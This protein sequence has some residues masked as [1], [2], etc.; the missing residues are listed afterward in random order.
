MV[1][2]VMMK[3]MM[4]GVVCKR[5]GK[6]KRETE[7]RNIKTLFTTVMTDREKKIP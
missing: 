6:R 2:V 4:R 3:M 7:T 5:E 1:V